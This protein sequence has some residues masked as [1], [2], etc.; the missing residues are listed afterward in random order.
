MKPLIITTLWLFCCATHAISEDLN[1]ESKYLGFLCSLQ[2]VESPDDL[3][4]LIPDCPPP[5]VDAGDDNTEILVKTKLFGLD[6]KGEF[7][8]HQGILVSHG[9]EVITKN[10]E[11]GHRT[12]LEALAILTEQTTDLKVSATLP[13]ALNGEDPS[14]GPEDEINLLVDGVAKNASFQLRLEM[15]RDSVSVGWGAQKVSATDDRQ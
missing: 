2:F 12:F 1:E 8:F 10:Y 7:N 13:I 14:D 15:R 3:K 6:A 5:T 4:K 9:F 11:D